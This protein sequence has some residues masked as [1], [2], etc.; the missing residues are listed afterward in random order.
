MQ[1]TSF[2]KFSFTPRVVTVSQP[3]YGHLYFYEIGNPIGLIL[4]SKQYLGFVSRTD[5]DLT[6]L[7][8]TAEMTVNKGILLCKNV[9]ERRK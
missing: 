1:P 8:M 4:S 7:A 2:P 3:I 6:N 9:K 5:L